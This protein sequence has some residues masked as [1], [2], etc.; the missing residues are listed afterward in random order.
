MERADDYEEDDQGSAERLLG[1]DSNHEHSDQEERGEEDDDEDDEDE[2]D[3]AKLMGFTD[4]DSHS[5]DKQRKDKKPKVKKSISKLS[6]KSSPAEEGDGFGSV[7]LRIEST[8]DV[9]HQDMTSQRLPPTAILKRQE[10]MRKI[11]EKHTSQ[12]AKILCGIYCII[13]I[14]GIGCS[15]LFFARTFGMKDLYIVGGIFTTGGLLFTISFIVLR[16]TVDR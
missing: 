4:H 7:I 16:C 13:V 9:K 11:Y 8:P 6:A 3:V 1:D 5:S 2:E 15:L 14:L 12:T 10:K